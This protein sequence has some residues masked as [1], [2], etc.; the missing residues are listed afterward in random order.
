MWCGVLTVRQPSDFNTLNPI[1]IAGTKGKGSTA[2]FI[3]SILRRFTSYEQPGATS[4][5]KVGLYTSPH[6]KSV[7]ERIQIDGKPLAEEQFA[8]YFFEV[9]DRLENAAKA[10]GED[11]TST[12][13]KPVYFRYLTLMAFHTFICEK[14]DVNVVECGIGGAYDSTN[15]IESPSVV[16]IT[17]LGI[18]HVGVLGT[19]I[20]EIAWHKAGIMK[21]GSV[22][23]TPDSQPPTAKDVLQKVADEKGCQLE[24]VQPLEVIGN[25]NWKLG[26]QGVFQNINAAVAVRITTKWLRDRGYEEGPDFET[27][28]ANGLRNVQWP[29]RC[30][31]KLSQGIKWCIDGAHTL[32]SINLAGKWFASQLITNS[33]EGQSSTKPIHPQPRFLIFNQQTRDAAALAQELFRTLS[34]ALNDPQPFTH[35]IFCTNTTF[36]DT[37]FKPD[38]VSVNT[39][40][41]DV[42]ALTV[43]RGLGETWAQIDPS[44]EVRVV[45]TIEEAVDL[46]QAFAKSRQD[47]HG[48]TNGISTSSDNHPNTESGVT[49]FVT[50]SLH[51]V[52]GFLEVLDTNENAMADQQSRP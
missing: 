18:D 35:V 33:A 26:L 41:S 34:D 42:E 20:E 25:G 46:V 17:N 23:F 40:T 29:G 49:A 15:V 2:A 4:F 32:E 7:R 27:R 13:A 8:R 48:L 37:G 10:A 45:R 24:F 50:G 14:V 19:T 6:L 39:N 31:T 5:S 52:G 43:Q 16:G 12:S 28:L 3:S 47:S 9:W 38:L 30:Q 51:L 11:P 44:A 36:R 21:P 22:C 1:H